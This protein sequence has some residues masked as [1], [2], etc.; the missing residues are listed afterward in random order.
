MYIE[1]NVHSMFCW[2]L[3]AAPAAPGASLHLQ[4][5]YVCLVR[6]TALEDYGKASRLGKVFYFSRAEMLYIFIYLIVGMLSHS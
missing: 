6:Q 1:A 3:L 4:T 2:T 5:S